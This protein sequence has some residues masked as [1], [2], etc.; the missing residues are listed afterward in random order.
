[1]TLQRYLN[2]GVILGLLPLWLQLNNDKTLIISVKSIDNST[3]TI[4]N[5]S[6][7]SKIISHKE[8]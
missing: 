1:M 7:K 8:T 5:L 4:L 2:C 6:C 3:K